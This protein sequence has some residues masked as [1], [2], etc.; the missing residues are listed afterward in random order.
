MLPDLAVQ[1][2]TFEQKIT[3]IL[4]RYPVILQLMRFIAIGLLNVKN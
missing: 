4:N 1:Q 3:G 2:N